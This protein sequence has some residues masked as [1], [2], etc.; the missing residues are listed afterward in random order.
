MIAI[1]TPGS[2]TPPRPRLPWSRCYACNEISEITATD[3]NI[4]ADLY[5]HGQSGACPLCHENL[6]YWRVALAMVKGNFMRL[7]PFFLI[8]AR[9]TAFQT[10]VFRDKITQF[11]LYAEGLPKNA[12]ILNVNIGGEGMFC[13]EGGAAI[14]YF[15]IQAG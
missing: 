11:D 5:L 8:G 10:K 1:Q 13:G 9:P 2:T 4:I 14:E 3:A 7:E 15:A 12:L 6:D